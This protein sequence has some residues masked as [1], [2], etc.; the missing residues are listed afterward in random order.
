MR[1]E[2]DQ[3]EN[4]YIALVSTAPYGGILID[5]YKQTFLQV[6]ATVLCE[7]LRYFILLYYN[8]TVT[9]FFF[10]CKKKHI[11]CAKVSTPKFKNL[12]FS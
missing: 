5:K 11:T 7:I 4:N 3:Y 10:Q 8:I 1:K 9:T 2:I 12:F 6:S